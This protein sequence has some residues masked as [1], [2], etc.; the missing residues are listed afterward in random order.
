MVQH[1]VPWA[2]IDGMFP[3]WLAAA[4][5]CRFQSELPRLPVG[6]DGET[7]SG[8]VIAQLSQL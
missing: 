3:K 7:N 8:A 2:M 5:V 4:F 1:H 6:S